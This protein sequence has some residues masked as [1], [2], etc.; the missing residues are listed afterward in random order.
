MREAALQRRRKEAEDLLRWHQKLL[1][2]ER[3]IA[4]LEMAASNVINQVPAARAAP[5]WNKESSVKSLDASISSKYS[6]DFDSDKENGAVKENAKQSES[7]NE[8]RQ[9]INNITD[10]I[11]ELYKLSSMQKSAL[12][13]SVQTES[14]GSKSHTSKASIISKP[15]SVP[16]ASVRVE[17]DPDRKT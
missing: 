15:K 3:K 14:S 10:E 9:N 1:K 11:T 2:E 7:F 8:I 16:E 12:S 5:I 4:D 6:T 17:G 13:D